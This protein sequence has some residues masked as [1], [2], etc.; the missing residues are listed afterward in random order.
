MLLKKGHNIPNGFAVTVDGLASDESEWHGAVRRA[1][2]RLAPPWVARS[3][4][5]AED[6]DLTAY[7]GLF[8]TV[9]D[10]NEA[11]AVIEAICEVRDSVRNPAATAYARHNGLDPAEISMA[12]LVQRLVIADTSGVAFSRDPVTGADIV[13]VEANYGLGGTVV[14]GSVTPD[15]YWVDSDDR[16]TERRLGSKREK[17]VATTSAARIRRLETSELERAASAITD[18][19]AAEVARLTRRLAR[20][21][22]RPVDVEWAFARHDLFVLQARPI[23]TL[24]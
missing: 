9:I 10:L 13:C 23:T 21:L 20:E 17:L 11:R 3:S 12:V 4:S 5:T 18:D 19:E 15:S 16:V 14:D 7:P 2:R 24:A 22:G 8:T 6:S 1:L